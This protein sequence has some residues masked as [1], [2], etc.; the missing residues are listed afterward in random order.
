LFP[1]KSEFGNRSAAFRTVADF[2]GAGVAGSRQVQITCFTRPPGQRWGEYGDAAGV[3][4]GTA[5]ADAGT[6]VS[7]AITPAGVSTAATAAAGSQQ[8]EGATQSKP[9]YGFY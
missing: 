4:A 1:T 6:A 2:N 7:T 5:T 8:A 3:A 9:S